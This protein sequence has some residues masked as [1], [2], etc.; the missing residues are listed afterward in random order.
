M[1]SLRIQKVNAL[2][3]ERLSELLQR[4]ISMKAGVLV[5]IAKVDTTRDL[6][7]TRVS[8][9][10]FPEKEAEYVRQTLRQETRRLEKALHRQLTM[11]IKPRLSFEIDR[12]EEEADKVEK[13]LKKIS[14]E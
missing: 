1:P 9:S 2:I 6:R 3:Q 10:A 11:K 5:T 13:I 12:T 8:V 7:Y 14:E 4:E